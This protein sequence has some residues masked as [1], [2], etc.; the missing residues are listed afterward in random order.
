MT[1]I[2]GKTVPPDLSRKRDGWKKRH[3]FKENTGLRGPATGGVSDVSDP[4]AAGRVVRGRRSA[5]LWGEGVGR[6]R[7]IVLPGGE[8]RICCTHGIVILGLD[9][10][11]CQTPYAVILGLDPRISVGGGPRVGPEDDV[12]IGEE[13]APPCWA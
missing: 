13:A 10:M 4:C 6:A 12:N 11:I 8:P 7:A 3:C 5:V 9:P 2:T 1:G